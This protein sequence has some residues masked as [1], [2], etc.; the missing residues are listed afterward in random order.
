MSNTIK[1]DE[2][3]AAAQQFGAETGAG[4]DAQVKFW[5]KTF[6]GGYHGVVDLKASKHGTG[7]DDAQKLAEAYVKAQNGAVVFDAKAA[8][9]QKLMSCLRTGIKLGSWP[10]GGNGEPLATVN[11]LMTMRQQLKKAGNKVDDAFNT[12][13][14]Y[15]REQLKRDVIIGDTELREFC[16]KKQR[17]PKEDEEKVEAIRKALD[18][19]ISDGYKSANLVSARG[20]LQS[21]LSALAKAKNPT[22]KV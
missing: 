18:K 19:L 16:L 15:A 6:E 14:R 11:N 2:I 17:T 1:F 12:C 3:L 5:L 22:I 10:K 21:E 7:V 20:S 13:L 4:K 9:Q 8:N